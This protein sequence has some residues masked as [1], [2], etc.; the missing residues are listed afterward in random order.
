MLI[1]YTNGSKFKTNMIY[2]PY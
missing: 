1:R 2:E